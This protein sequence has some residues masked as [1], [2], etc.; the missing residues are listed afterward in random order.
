MISQ[1]QGAADFHCA[2]SV[3]TRSNLLCGTCSGVKLITEQ[4]KADIAAFPFN[5]E[6]ELAQLGATALVGEET[7]HTLERQRAPQNPT[8][9]LVICCSRAAGRT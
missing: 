3:V 5:A 8:Q 4:D 9:L 6:A 1:L 7:F 2:Q